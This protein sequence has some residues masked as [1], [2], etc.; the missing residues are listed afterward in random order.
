MAK[1]NLLPWRE[2]LRQTQKQHYIMSLA[3]VSVLVFIV[4]YFA[5]Q[6]IDQQIRNQNS[7][8]NY[9]N[10]R[11]SVLDSQINE[12]K[13]INAAKDEITLRMSLIEQLQ[14]SRNLTPI[15]FD[16]LA[17]LVPEGVSFATMSRSANQIKIVGMSESNNRLSAFMRALESS[18]VFV[19]PVLSSIIADKSGVIAVS[20][21]E[22]TFSV[23]PQYGPIEIEQSDKNQEQR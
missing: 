11:I 1:I 10:Q 17:R 4:F 14:V 9:L 7:R 19:N 2:S 22:L 6:I 21:F 23:S 16:E 20:D 3:G 13:E 15:I 5:G 12:I 8:N 18:K